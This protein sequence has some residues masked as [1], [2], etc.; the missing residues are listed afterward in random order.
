MLFRSTRTSETDGKILTISL[1]NT[2][3]NRFGRLYFNVGLLMQMPFS[4]PSDAGT[5]GESGCPGVDFEA[6]KCF[7]G[8][9]RTTTPEDYCSAKR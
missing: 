5:F 2:D 8:R 4:P 3:V 7:D 1:F 9:H 6:F